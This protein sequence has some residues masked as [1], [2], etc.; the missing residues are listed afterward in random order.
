MNDRNELE[1]LRARGVRIDHKGRIIVSLPVPE[2]EFEFQSE[3]LEPMI[4]DLMRRDVNR[5][6]GG[7]RGRRRRR[8][9]SSTPKPG[10]RAQL[11][12][13]LQP[14]PIGRPVIGSEARVYVQTSIA[15]TTRQILAERG[16]TLADVF[17]QCA[18]ELAH[19]S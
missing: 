10:K 16:L 11:D 15:Q 14:S 8:A 17:D 3:G 19:A 4:A 13:R 5:H 7:S 1:W 9:P 6:T 12:D 2:E 18:R